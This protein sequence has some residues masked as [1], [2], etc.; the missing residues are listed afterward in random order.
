MRIGGERVDVVLGAGMQRVALADDVAAAQ[1]ERVDAEAFGEQVEG[2]LDAQHHLTEAV[3]AEGAGR[4]GVRVDGLRVDAPH[5]GAVDEGRLGHAVEHDP[6]GV[7]AVGAGVA[8]DVDVH[9]G[10]AAVGVGAEGDRHAHRVAHGGAEE[11]LGARELV[12]HGSSGAQDGEGDEVFGEDLL[13]AAEAAAHACGQHP[14]PVG[15]EVEHAGELV[16][17]QERHLGAGADDQAPVGVDPAEGAVGL[18]LRVRDTAG[19]PGAVDAHGTVGEGGGDVAADLLVQHGDDVARGVGHTVVRRAVGMQQGSAGGARLLRVEH[20]R[21]HLVLDP[22]RAAPGF[23][24]ARALGDDDGHPLADEAQDVVDHPRVVG[25]VGAVMVA[26]GGEAHGGGV[27]GGQHRDDSRDGRRRGRVDRHDAG[28]RVR[29]SQHPQHEGALR[30]P[31]RIGRHRL[32]ERERLEA[33]HDPSRGRRRDR[34][35]HAAGHGGGVLAG[36]VPGAR[37]AP[38][39]GARLAHG[40]EHRRAD[41]LAD[42]AV[43]RAPAEVAAQGAVEVGEVVGGQSGSGHGHA[44]G[45]EA[46]LE[47]EARR[48]RLLHRMQVVAVGQPGRRGHRAP[49]HPH[50][51]DDARVHRLPVEDHAARAAVAGVAALLHLAVPVLAQEGP[52]RLARPRVGL[53]LVT[54]DLEPHAA[55]SVRMRSASTPLT[56]RRQSAEPSG[57]L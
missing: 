20:G 8:Q 2:R 38:R 33:L 18:E 35:A 7:V 30:G 27:G 52:Q 50:R 31:G 6:G 23:G 49:R 43:A 54:V 13:L 5:G 51:R 26:G 37:G 4:D 55:S 42:R 45:A 34:C 19:L 46:A 25:V 40:A 48:D 3:A 32:V 28:V 9:G 53:D 10:E 15:V 56:P 17:R 21:Q 22:Q 47:A 1:L 16:A 14:H 41:R 39:R 57:S 29:R 44:R 24:R 11:L 36:R 12:G